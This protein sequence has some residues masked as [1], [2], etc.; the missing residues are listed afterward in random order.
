MGGYKPNSLP[1]VLQTA[2]QPVQAGKREATT[3][4]IA[5][6]AVGRINCPMQPARFPGPLTVCRT[7]GNAGGKCKRASLTEP[8]WSRLR[9]PRGLPSKSGLCLWLSRLDTRGGNGGFRWGLSVS[10]E[11]VTRTVFL[12]S[13]SFLRLDSPCRTAFHTTVRYY[14]ILGHT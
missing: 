14:F 5:S 3:K 11:H 4:K 2:Q 13:A 7:R 10:C 1:L 8:C 12:A 9:A 6:T